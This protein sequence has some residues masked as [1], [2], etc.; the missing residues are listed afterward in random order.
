[1]ILLFRNGGNSL[2]SAFKK[3]ATQASLRFL[4]AA[5]LAAVLPELLE[6]K[7]SCKWIREM[8]QIKQNG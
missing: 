2:A 4:Q 7:N 5:C 6:W 1:M 8:N 3:P